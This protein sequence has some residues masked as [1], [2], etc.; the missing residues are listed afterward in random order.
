MSPKQTFT[1]GFSILAASRTIAIGDIHGC[2][3]AFE[4]LLAAVRPRPDDTIITLGDYVDRG[5]DCR[6]TI[7]RLLALGR[8]CRLIPLLGNHEEMMLNVYDGHGE[9]YVDWL[10]FGGNA[11]LDSYDTMRPEDVPPAHIEFLR[12]CRPIYETEKR[13]YVHGN[14][15][16]DV[17]LSEQPRETLL[18]DSVKARR[19]GRHV[20][21][22][23]AI[24]GH[25][26]QKSG[27]ILDL[28]YLKCI[29]TW[30]YGDG[31]LTALDVESGEAWQANKSG[32]MR[33]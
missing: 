3:A 24:V 10:L 32:R 18:W 30:C 16:A 26:S 15:M 14:Y 9:L 25:A 28:G 19:P 5:P 23:T 7:E 20:S 11:T 2:L 29:D 13:F 6:G 8:E 12:A 17:P 33:R 4:A 21:G 22:K 31:W 27:E 1:R